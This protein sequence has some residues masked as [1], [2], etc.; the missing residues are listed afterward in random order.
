MEGRPSLQHP[1]QDH[2]F[3]LRGDLFIDRLSAGIADDDI[4]SS[5]LHFKILYI[6]DMYNITPVPYAVNQILCFLR[7]K[8]EASPLPL[9]GYMY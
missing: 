7:T 1:R 3:D 4:H 6:Y 5:T 8:R 9:S 2:I